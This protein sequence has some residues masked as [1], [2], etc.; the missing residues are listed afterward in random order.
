MRLLAALLFFLL[1]VTAPAVVAA[2][3]TP[4]ISFRPGEQIFI[5]GDRINYY[6]SSNLYVAEG[7]VEIR[8]GGNVLQ[9]ERILLDHANKV[10]RA[11]GDVR[12][13]DGTSVLTSDRVV[14]HLDDRTGVIFGGNIYLRDSGYRF[15]GERI[16][17]LSEDEFIIRRGSITTCD[18][19]PEST[20]SW[21]IS[22]R[23]IWVTVGGY[24]RVQN[25]LFYVQGVP[26]LFLPFGYFPVKTEREFG[27]LFP[28]LTY[29]ERKGFEVHQ[30]LFIPI[31]DS[32]DATLYADY[33]SNLGYGASGEFR[34]VWR[35]GSYGNLNVR[36]VRQTKDA[37]GR[38]TGLR[39]DRFT[40]DSTHRYN[41]SEYEAAVADIHTVSDRQY[42]ADLAQTLEEQTQQFTRSEVSYINTF[43]RVSV[44]P[45]ADLYER[46]GRFYEESV[47]RLPHLEV[48]A[49]PQVVTP[50]GTVVMARGAA[51]NFVNKP[52]GSGVLEFDTY[53]TQGQRADILLRVEQPVSAGPVHV[54]PFAAGRE[55]AYRSTFGGPSQNREM[56]ALGMRAA[57]PLE[58]SWF[59]AP[60]VTAP[61]TN[62]VTHRFTP[63]ARYL[64]MP[65]VD[66]AANPEFDEL[67][68]MRKRSLVEYG[69]SNDVFWLDDGKVGKLNLGIFRQYALDATGDPDSPLFG[70]LKVSFPGGLGLSAT[71]YY[72]PKATSYKNYYGVY[73][74]EGSAYGSLAAL[75]FHRLTNYAINDQSRVLVD[76][77]IDADY[78]RYEADL[79]W[80]SRELWGTVSRTFFEHIT[81]SY[82]AR[83][84]LDRNIFL[85]S[86]YGLSYLSFCNC[87]SVSSRFIQR[88]NND[89]LFNVTFT[90]V[91]IG[92]V[93]NQ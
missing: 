78:F 66:Q 15:S 41:F 19:G 29:S 52:A 73:R 20:P 90:L 64:F 54:V 81:L 7:G 23:S 59:Y 67:D 46:L 3:A 57:V 1:A 76:E 37:E 84:S 18:C 93:G 36:F 12:L 22:A 13:S 79:P 56:A 32:A 68:R 6:R 31:G 92:S 86:V 14:A 30:G 69:V 62:L 91:G 71:E 65:D 55:T 17:K 45:Q 35:R 60:F 47:N 77:E 43:E 25:A 26:V 63:A 27:L 80:A 21:H 58:R 42:F 74:V 8:Y 53:R 85:E 16:E 44:L 11:S 5:K 48:L 33:Y 83:Y 70:R 88:P 28:S 38:D 75:E 61:E 10:F 51:D 24:A 34:Y 82:G 50:F 40:V 9:A 87:W 72:D 39:I 49:Q 89:L 2:Q 4:S